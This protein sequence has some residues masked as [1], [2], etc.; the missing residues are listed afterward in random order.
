MHACLDAR[1]HGAAVECAAPTVNY[2]VVAGK[3]FWEVYAPHVFDG[4]PLPDTS[5]KQTGDLH[6]ADIFFNGVM[7]AGFRY[8]HAGFFCELVDGKR[9]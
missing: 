9:P 7:G 6:R 2:Q 4:K 3:I 5:A 1:E 8:E